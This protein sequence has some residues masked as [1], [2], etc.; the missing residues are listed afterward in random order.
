MNH[1]HFS[2]LHS[3]RLIPTIL[4]KLYSQSILPE[5]NLKKL[6]KDANYI[7]YFAQCYDDFTCSI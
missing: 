2:F 4:L 7:V 3:Y 5:D 1:I 6:A